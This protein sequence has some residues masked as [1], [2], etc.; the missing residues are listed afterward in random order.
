[1]DKNQCFLPVP[2]WTE[3]NICYIEK[4]FQ[5]SNKLDE[6]LTEMSRS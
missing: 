3:E 2:L 6:V 1:M 5:G 4:I